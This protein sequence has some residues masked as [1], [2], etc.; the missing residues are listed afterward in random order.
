M[1]ILLTGSVGFIGSAFRDLA[2][3]QGHTVG[4]LVRPESRSKLPSHPGTVPVIGSLADPD[5]DS[6]HRFAPELCVHAA[7]ITTPGAYLN[8]PENQKLLDW[9]QTFLGKLIE[10]GVRKI[11]ALGSCA[12]YFE[13]LAS[14]GT[15]SASSGPPLEYVRCKRAL[16]QWLEMQT[17]DQGVECSWGRVFYPYGPQE[18]EQKLCTALI[19]TIQ[20]G[21]TIELKTPHSIKD[22]IYVNDLASAI[23]AL[24]ENP[25]GGEFDLGTGHGVAIQTVGS[26]IATLLDAPFSLQ[27]PP[28]EEATDVTVADAGRLRESGWQPKVS[29]TAGLKRLISEIAP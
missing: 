25:S 27:A 10:Q 12:E 2:L 5:W 21:E 22:Y 15:Q 26:T 4:A 19:R 23:L 3:Q 29:L 13:P 16:H 17:Q 28:E 14:E 9:S 6:I 24:A 20:R 1:R 11:V 8:S 7:W 18:P